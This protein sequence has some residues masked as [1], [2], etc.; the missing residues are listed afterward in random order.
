MAIAAEN[1]ERA[2]R[3]YSKNLKRDES[4]RGQEIVRY[5]IHQVLTDLAYESLFAAATTNNK[6]IVIRQMTSW[7]VKTEKEE[8]NPVGFALL[9][10]LAIPLRGDARL[11]PKGP[12]NDII[13]AL[14][15]NVGNK[16]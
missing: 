4:H 6:D 3:D 1:L 7:I 16:V 5:S 13:T 10:T 8:N 14:V 15:L 2:V 11:N 12:A 9:D